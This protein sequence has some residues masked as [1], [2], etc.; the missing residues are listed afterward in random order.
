MRASLEMPKLTTSS[1]GVQLAQVSTANTDLNRSVGQSNGVGIIN[2]PATNV[3]N[4]SNTTYVMDIRAKN[5]DTSY[6]RNQDAM[7]VGT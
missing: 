7:F 4:N 3:T 2:A 5:T 6:Q 1:T